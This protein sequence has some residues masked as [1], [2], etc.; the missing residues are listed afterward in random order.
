MNY[1]YK[2]YQNDIPDAGAYS[3]SLAIDCEMMG[4]NIHRDRLCVIQ[5]YDPVRNQVDIIQCKDPA[6]DAPNLKTLLNRPNTV[7]LGHMIRLDLA[8]LYKHL[9]VMPQ[10]VYCTRTASRIGQTYGAS[11]NYLDLISNILGKKIDKS[12][13]SSYWGAE[14]LTDKQIQYVCQDVIFLHAL[15]EKLDAIISHESRQDLAEKAMKMIPDRAYFDATGWWN[16]DIL[17]YPF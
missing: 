3:H 8:Y 17:S 9:G 1:T 15:K 13:T 14:E 11:H 12:E 4:L 10:N 7:F 16:E 2:I 6:Y 5:I